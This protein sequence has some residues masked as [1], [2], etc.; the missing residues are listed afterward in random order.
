MES[1]TPI[2]IFIADDHK[3][4][5]ESLRALL[6]AQ[7]DVRVVGEAGDGETAVRLAAE[8]Q[9]DI[10]IMDVTLAGFNGIEATERIL[11][12]AANVKVI[13]LSMHSSRQFIGGMLAAGASSY[14]LKDCV[15]EELNSAVRAVMAGQIYLSNK[16]AE[17]VVDD[18]R[19]LLTKKPFFTPRQ[20]EILRLLAEGMNVK[21]IASQCGLSVKTVEMHRQHIMDKLGTRSIATLTKYALQEGMASLEKQ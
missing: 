3:L 13:A 16:V 5:R 12:R 15:F 1:T 21:E 11:E 4:M 14:L 9:P 17:D 6:E 10:V 7:P 2:R 19:R 18:Y 8:L 20:K